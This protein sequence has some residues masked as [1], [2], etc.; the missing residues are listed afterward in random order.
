MR[1]ITLR[2]LEELSFPEYRARHIFIA[3]LRLAIF[4]GFW[5]L[6]VIFLKE[7]LAETKPVTITV[8]VC[9][10]VTTICYYNIFNNKFLVPSFTLEIISDLVA[11]TAIVYLT[12]GPESEYYIIYIF[13][14][15]AAGL[16]YNYKLALLVSF[17]S[18]ICYGLFLILCY[19]QVIPPLLIGL[20]GFTSI[21]VDVPYLHPFLLIIFLA[22]A[23]YAT[24]IAHI[25]TQMRERILEARNKELLALQQMSSTIRTVTSLDNVLVQVVNGVLEGLNLTMCLLMLHEKDE[26][27]IRCIP[28]DM[29]PLASQI[30][31]MLGTRMRQLY[32]PAEAI[33]ENPAFKQL[34]QGRII[35][36][37]DIAEIVE[38]IK[39]EFAAEK[40]KEVQDKLGIK[41]VIAIPLVTGRE[42][43][44]S[45][46]GFT[47]EAFVEAKM[48]HTFQAFA[49]QAALAVEA[50]M[51]ISELRRKNIAL[52]EANR[53]KSEFLATMSHELRTPLTAIIGFSEL[54]LEGVMGSIKEEQNDSLK[55]VLG[56]ANNLLEMINN[57][58][59]LAKVDSG[60][61]ELSRHSFDWGEMLR[62]V[63]RTVA[64]LVQRKRHTLSM[65]IKPDIPAVFADEKRMQQV[66]LNLLSNA[67][68]FTPEEGKIHIKA[69]TFSDFDKFSKVHHYDDVNLTVEKGAYS[70][71]ILVCSV[72][73]S[74][75]GIPAENL[76]LIFDVFQQ[77]DS[78]VTRS[79]EG[80][81]L[82]LALV[83]QFVELHN[84]FV[85]VKSEEGVGTK[86]TFAFPVT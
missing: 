45:L 13:Y 77:V 52:V 38:G 25:F 11:M 36:R 51:L 60:K 17:L 63:E 43:I 26:K 2:V 70:S 79:Y 8:L 4:I 86:F 59:D 73:D 46:I 67:I 6:Y 47:T 32:F 62:R 14:A 50:A 71:G 66:I 21:E 61:M 41:R 29:H 54:L 75:I 23:V 42:V 18:F 39:P 65:E 69:E 5:F 40:F 76:P 81:G 64:P 37:R 48:V 49:D 84:G 57:L 12:G 27:R 74:G 78:S 28:P 53:V 1:S 9:F 58:L 34:K 20:G 83:K 55:E 24:R 82:G 30:E 16:F 3:K 68:K 56:N 7:Y 44:G 10:L 35:F 33:D 22:L 31:E 80:S 85:W 72:E 15:V 19:S